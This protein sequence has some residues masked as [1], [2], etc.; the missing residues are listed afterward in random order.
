MHISLHI[1]PTLTCSLFSSSAS[2]DFLFTYI[3]LFSCTY[4]SFHDYIHVWLSLT[5]SLVPYR[6]FIFAKYNFA[7]LWVTWVISICV[8]LSLFSTASDP[9]EKSPFSPAVPFYVQP[10]QIRSQYSFCK[11]SYC[12]WIYVTVDANTNVHA[13]K[14][15][16]KYT[17]IA[18]HTQMRAQSWSDACRAM[19]PS[20]NPICCSFLSAPTWGRKTTKTTLPQLIFFLCTQYRRSLHA[21]F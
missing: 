13:T 15:K 11:G 3:G 20:R 9:A 5:C 7:F 8:W 10:E 6:P 21:S 2:S 16:Y 14:H 12:K 18:T 19:C 1:W 4:F 17:R